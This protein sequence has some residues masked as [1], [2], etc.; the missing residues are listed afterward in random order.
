MVALYPDKPILI[1]EFGAGGI[2]GYHSM[3]AL[4]WSEEYQSQ[5]LQR[6]IE[7]ML[8]NNHVAGCF[9]WQYCDILSHPAR[10]LGRP[11]SSNNKGIVDEYRRPKLSY[12]TIRDLFA[13]IAAETG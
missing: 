11:R 1:T 10:A 4:K 9:I 13:R 3:P 5:H 8:G 12:F 6:S 2:P 7:T